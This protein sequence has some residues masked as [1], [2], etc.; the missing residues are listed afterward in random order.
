MATKVEG[1]MCIVRLRG[2]ENENMEIEACDV[3]FDMQI[4]VLIAIHIE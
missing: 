3:I 4:N 1:T 2:N